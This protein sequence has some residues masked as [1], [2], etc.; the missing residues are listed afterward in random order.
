MLFGRFGRDAQA[1]R[2]LLIGTLVEH[3][4]RERCTTL[5]GQPIDRLLYETIPFVLENLGL[6]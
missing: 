4:Q 2:N 1:V 5:R 6:G 3:A